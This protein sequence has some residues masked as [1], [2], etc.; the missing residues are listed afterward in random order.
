METIV[1]NLKLKCKEKINNSKYKELLKNAGMSVMETD[2]SIITLDAIEEYLIYL[3][4]KKYSSKIIKTFFSQKE[5]PLRLSNFFE[6]DDNKG[7]CKQFDYSDETFWRTMNWNETPIQNY[8][9][10]PPEHVLKSII[11]KKNLF[12]EIMIVTLDETIQVKDPLVV[13][14]K[15][16]DTNRY[17]IDWW[18]NDIDIPEINIKG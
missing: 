11:E 18:D 4:N 14:I 12:N 6:K 8:I 16:N 10:T 17:L 2:C 9:G 13:G 15:E 1:D 7:F 5:I 3:I